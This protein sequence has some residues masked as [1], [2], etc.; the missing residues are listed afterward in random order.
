MRKVES[1]LSRGEFGGFVCLGL[2]GLVA[3]CLYD[4]WPGD[5]MMDAIN[6]D[7]LACLLYTDSVCD[8]N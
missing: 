6:G 3:G 8:C 2:L 4:P 5:D 7:P 1:K